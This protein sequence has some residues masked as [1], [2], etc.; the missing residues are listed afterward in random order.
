MVCNSFVNSLEA[1]LGL[2]HI[3][4]YTTFI[5]K[6]VKRLIHILYIREVGLNYSMSP[7]E[8]CMQNHTE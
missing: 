5:T 2:C 1:E 4:I 6:I 8:G 7:C 3:Y